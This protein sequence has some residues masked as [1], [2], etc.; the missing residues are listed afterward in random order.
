MASLTLMGRL[1][2]DHAREFV[3]DIVGLQSNKKPI[4]KPV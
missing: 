3:F 2:T 4:D 1:C